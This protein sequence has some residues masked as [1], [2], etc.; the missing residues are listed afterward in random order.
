MPAKKS[1]KSSAADAAVET[2][3]FQTE[4]Q[5]LL[6]L[7][8]HSLYSNKEIFLRELIANASDACDR[9]RFLALTDKALYEDGDESLGIRVGVDEKKNTVSVRDNGIG[10]SRDEV[11]D[12]IGTIARSGTRR[13]LEQMSEKDARDSAF[14][15]QFGVGFYSAFL[16]AAQVT[17]LT[18][19][20]GAPAAEGVKWVS[21]GSGEYTVE[22]VERAERG[23]EIILKLHRDRKEY[24]DRHRLRAVIGKYSDHIS[25]PI[26]MLKETEKDDHGKEIPG[27]EPAWETV[28]KGSAL[29]ARARGE[30]SR[31]QYNAFYTALTYDPEPP[32][33]T[34]HN[35]VEGKMEYI[36]LF[37][38]PS[39]APF[40][41]WDR[42]RR[43]GIKLYVRRIFIAED[44][45]QLMPNYLRFVRG[46][47]DSADLPLNVSR[48]FLQQNKDIDKIRAA[49]VKKVLA[50]LKKI[51][52]KD[53]DQYAALWNEYGRVIKEGVIEDF[54]NRDAI[55][56]LLRFASTHT[57]AGEQQSV[58]LDDY[59]K[60]MPAKQKAI[61]YVTADSPASAKSSPHLEVFR[62]NDI[63]VLLLFDPVDE[64]VVGH[65]TDYQDKPLRSI[66]K[67]DLDIAELTGRASAGGEADAP[68]DGK[69][70]LEAL[71]GKIKAALG[72]KVKE[73][74]ISHRLVDS[75]A[76]LVADSHDLGGNMQRIL[77]AIGQDAPAAKPILE[78][79]PAHAIVKRIDADAPRL[80]DWASVLF[81]QAALA[82]GASLADPGEYVKRVNRL[83]AP[84]GG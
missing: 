43:H 81:D 23:T 80:E 11:I 56:R 34:L 25:L 26:K 13:F 45:R 15:G 64:W 57:G 61:Y 54:D 82:E 6:N 63:E 31:D 35:R 32:A 75:P 40:D 53:A 70:N 19:R 62:Q 1:A 18:R 65:L 44:A 78:I 73:V 22:A 33:V 8:I 9:L 17:L 10:M 84:G 5:Q 74:R 69:E 3:A 76:C 41:L 20:A 39:K 71:V 2:H 42:E 72:D 51:A 60:R 66:A 83:L 21:D 24:L 14:I 67:G 49:S 47:V 36:S 28:N 30:I 59:L 79:N 58:S 29:W 4:V 16:V 48:E 52:A 27:Q 77:Q 7:I 46:L 55:A 37:Y 50:E 68:A 38:I 12:N